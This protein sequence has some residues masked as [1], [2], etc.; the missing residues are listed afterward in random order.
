MP[1]NNGMGCTV[2]GTASAENSSDTAAAALPAG[3]S[4]AQLSS[5]T[6]QQ[7]Q[8]RQQQQQ[9]RGSMQRPGR[10]PA[11]SQPFDT[12]TAVSTEASEIQTDFSKV[13]QCLVLLW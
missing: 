3:P 10:R 2:R 9:A 8:G 12:S 11:S 4:Q 1:S 7:Q 5:S 13:S 6:R